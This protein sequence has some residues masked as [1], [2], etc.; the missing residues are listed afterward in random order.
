MSF[1]RRTTTEIYDAIAQQLSTQSE[2]QG[3]Q[4]NI[5][6]S[7]QLLN[8]LNTTIKVATWRLFGFAIAFVISTFEG[9]IESFIQ[10]IER[11]IQDTRVGNI[12]WLIEISKLFQLDDII[13]VNDE[14]GEVGYEVIDET[15]QI[16]KYANVEEISEGVVLKVRKES[17]ALSLEETSKFQTYINK[18][19]AAG[20]RIF[21]RSVDSDKLDLYMNIVYRAEMAL[22]DIK[23]EVY[24]V[25]NEYLEELEFNSKFKVISL[26]DRLQELDYIIDVQFHKGIGTPI[27][28]V[29]LEFLYDYNSFSG[30]MEID[31][32]LDD[33]VTFESKNTY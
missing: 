29:S 24:G 31:T 8:D 15:K 3:L 11:R 22:G 12:F 23:D 26:I 9:N 4:P 5:D 30:W 1:K 16:V 18:R 32:P 10:L 6:N 14:T 27:S 28:G 25:I 17:G 33:T 2:L 19:K 7:Q 13:V 20:S 21:V